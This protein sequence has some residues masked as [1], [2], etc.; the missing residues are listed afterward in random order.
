MSLRYVYSICSNAGEKEKEET[1]VAKQEKTHRWDLRFSITNL[2]WYS[3]K[4]EDQIMR[5]S[6]FHVTNIKDVF[7]S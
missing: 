1:K 2:L 5:N 3:N 4:E 7:L 6:S